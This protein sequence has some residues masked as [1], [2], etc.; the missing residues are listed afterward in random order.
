MGKPT[1]LKALLMAYG[2]RKFYE[3]TSFYNLVLEKLRNLNSQ[4]LKKIGIVKDGNLWKGDL[5]T[6]TLWLD[7]WVQNG[8][9]VGCEDIPMSIDFAQ[10]RARGG[11]FR[12][13][14]LCDRFEHEIGMS[15]NAIRAKWRR[16]GKDPEMGI[17]KNEANVLVVDLSVFMRWL[18]DHQV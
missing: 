10:L 2:G 15:L 17:E 9:S 1:K 7:E 18:D 8:P 3:P 5:Q 11:K 4:E 13:G 12:L 6:V 14:Q 16:S